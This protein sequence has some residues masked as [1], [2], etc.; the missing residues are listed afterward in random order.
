LLPRKESNGH[1]GVFAT[2]NNIQQRIACCGK[3]ATVEALPRAGATCRRRTRAFSGKVEAGFPQKMRPNKNLERVPDST[4]AERA[5][6][7]VPAKG[8]APDSN[9][10]NDVAA[11]RQIFSRVRSPKK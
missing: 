2:G 7:R 4:K 9:F 8:G 11:Y 5:R 1:S 10:R 6:G 3:L